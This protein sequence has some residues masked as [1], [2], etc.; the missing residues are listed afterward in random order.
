MLNSNRQFDVVANLFALDRPALFAG[1]CR[2]L[3]DPVELGEFA[4]VGPN[5]GLD[6][7]RE[8][9][10][11]QAK[12][13]V[14]LPIGGNVIGAFETDNVLAFGRLGVVAASFGVWDEFETEFA[15][16]HPQS[17]SVA[18]LGFNS[19]EMTHIG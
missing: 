8:P 5:F 3:V 18:D 12:R 13:P 7:P 14:G 10:C 17:L 1:F 15:A 11:G 16:C 6:V 19:S 2:R 9:I 4:V